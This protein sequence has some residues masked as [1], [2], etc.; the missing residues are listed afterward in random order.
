M[1]YS[2]SRE[3]H[4]RIEANRA[5]GRLCGGSS[6]C[7]SRATRMTIALLERETGTW[8]WS[9]MV[10]CKKH[11]DQMVAWP[12]Y[13]NG[14]QMGILGL[15]RMTKVEIAN[16]RHAL[17]TRPVTESNVREAQHLMRVDAAR[18]EAIRQAQR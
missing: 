3:T 4:E 9:C 16:Q 18:R 1:G 7:S 17:E 2:I 13:T 14:A 11:A 5:A 6:R 8:E 12:A 10:M 15:Q